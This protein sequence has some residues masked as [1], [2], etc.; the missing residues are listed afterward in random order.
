MPYDIGPSGSARGLS[1]LFGVDLPVELLAIVLVK[2]AQKSNESAKVLNMR[3]TCRVA[4]I[5]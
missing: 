5:W 1:Y 2:S 4:K 3:F